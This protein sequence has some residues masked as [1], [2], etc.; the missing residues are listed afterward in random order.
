MIN[1]WRNW[2]FFLA[3]NIDNASALCIKIGDINRAKEGE[4]LRPQSLREVNALMHEDWVEFGQWLL[5]LGR[6]PKRVDINT[7]L[8]TLRLHRLAKWH[9]M[10]APDHIIPA[11]KSM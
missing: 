2:F 6:L 4:I 9:V 8:N 7:K 10:Q 1:L 3:A 11:E 5:T